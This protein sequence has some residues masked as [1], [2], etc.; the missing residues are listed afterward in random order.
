MARRKAQAPFLITEEKIA[1]GVI[2]LFHFVGA[3]MLM[4]SKGGWYQLAKDLVPLNLIF[5]CLVAFKYQKSYSQSFFLFC[6]IA[7]S[8]GF[9]AEWVGVNYGWLF[10]R[11]SYGEV[12]GIKV[13]NT[14]LLIG[15]NWV[16]LLY[17]AGNLM[18]LIPV[19]SFL[20]ILG[21]ILIL[22]ATDYFLEPVAMKNDFWTW[23][24]GSI[25]VRNY[26][27][28]AAVSSVG[29]ILLFQL[30][31]ELK[32]KVAAFTCLIQFF[33]FLIQNIL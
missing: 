12:L 24:D 10:G 16:L 19:H 23:L 17:C 1:I 2:G 22:L 7:Y 31:V 30:K 27:G 15:M 26:M 3:I 33:F 32:N 18:S 14:P 9:L 11:Y 4:F 6:A 20:K 8:F 21:T 29:S 28:W 25:P 13:A 5:T